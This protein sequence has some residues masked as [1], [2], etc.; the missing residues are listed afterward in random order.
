[1]KLLCAIVFTL[2]TLA[3][4]F[5]ENNTEYRVLVDNIFAN[6]YERSLNSDRRKIGCAD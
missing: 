2:V 1:M 4:I 5:D 6:Q 3:E